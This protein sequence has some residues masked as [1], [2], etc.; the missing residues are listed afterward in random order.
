MRAIV[1]LHLTL[2][3]LLLIFIVVSCY[4]ENLSDQF[5]PSEVNYLASES[6][7]GFVKLTWQDPLDEDFAEV[8][9]SYKSVTTKV[10]RGIESH[11]IHNLE[12]DSIYRFTV[13]TLDVAGNFSRGRHTHNVPAS[14]PHIEWLSD[15][16]ILADTNDHGQLTGSLKAKRLLK[17]TDSDGYITFKINV[18]RLS[19]SV[20]ISSKYKSFL[21]YGQKTYTMELESRGDITMKNCINCTEIPQTYKMEVISL[22]DQEQFDIIPGFCQFVANCNNGENKQEIR[23]NKISLKR[24]SLVELT[25]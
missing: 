20:L 2:I 18:T 14:P 6:G 16:E 7:D 19:D 8:E 23:W 1:K 13:R 5:P 10:P 4:K 22:S 15:P 24:L 9:I 3:I 25:Q 17:N 12:N 21:V 11:V